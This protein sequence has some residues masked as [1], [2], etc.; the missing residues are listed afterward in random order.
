V[1]SL[2]WRVGGVEGREREK[3]KAREKE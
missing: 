1:H 2:T 3:E